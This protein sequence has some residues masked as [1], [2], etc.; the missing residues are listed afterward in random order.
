ML[1]N[2]DAGTGRIWRGCDMMIE[3]TELWI[4]CER[5][6]EGDGTAVRDS[7]GICIGTGRSE[8]DYGM[9]NA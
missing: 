6:I 2:S 1:L 8:W 5:P 3:K 4:T 7:S 9:N